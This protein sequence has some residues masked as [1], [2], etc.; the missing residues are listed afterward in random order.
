MRFRI[1]P[2][3]YLLTL[4]LLL[5][6][7]ARA[8]LWAFAAVAVHEAGHAAAARLRGYAV[9]SLTLYPYGAAMSLN[10]EMDPVSGII[11]GL[12]GPAANLL[13]AAALLALWWLF[14]AVYPF[15]RA[16]LYANVGIALFN[17]LPVYPLDGSRVVAGMASRK[18]AAVKGMQK[19][20]V[21]LGILLFLLFVLSAVL[22]AVSFTLGVTAVFLFAG[23]AFGGRE[24]AYVSVL[25]AKGKNYLAGVRERTVL[26]SR[27]APLVRLF[28]YVDGR[29]VTTF[30]VV[31]RGEDGVREC[32]VLGEE[33]VRAAAGRGR[34]C[35]TV[36]ECLSECAGE[37][38]HPLPPARG[39]GEPSYIP[40]RRKREK[41]RRMPSPFSRG[42]H[43]VDISRKLH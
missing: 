1:H 20:G 14:P 38:A 12:A 13:A 6:G 23:A 19:A 43:G 3:F 5:F 26:V 30:K 40:E 9:R 37:S 16:F 18:L 35:R 32:A 36:G 28:H 25:A 33:D 4:L 31:E 22:G 27:D 15:T 39:E 29:S 34:L 41:R 10:E 2:L 42:R 7:Q 17:L 21:M 24:Q 8:L 11:V